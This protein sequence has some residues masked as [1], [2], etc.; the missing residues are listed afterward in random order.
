MPFFFCR[1]REKG[2]RAS[3]GIF[4]KRTQ[5]EKVRS[6]SIRV[7]Y[8]SLDGSSLF[9]VECQ[10]QFGSVWS[11]SA[12][13]FGIEQQALAPSWKRTFTIPPKTAKNRLAI[14]ENSGDRLC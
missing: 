2:V 14:Q 4:A 5:I 1:R 11:D 8:V 7:T 3:R 10:K 12:N 9:S 6:H 13:P